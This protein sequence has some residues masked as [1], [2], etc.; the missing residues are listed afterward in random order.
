MKP[1]TT[2][3][4]ESK[5]MN[6]NDDE[7]KVCDDMLKSI[8][9]SDYD[10]LSKMDY[11]DRVSTTSP[12][13]GNKYFVEFKNPFA[14][15]HKFSN[16]NKDTIAPEKE[17][18]IQCIGIG[19]KFGRIFL[20]NVW[21]KAEA[22]IQYKKSEKIVKKDGSSFNT[23][24]G[25]Y[26]TRKNVNYYKV[27]GLKEYRKP[28]FYCPDDNISKDAYNVFIDQKYIIDL[29]NINDMVKRTIDKINKEA[30]RKREEETKREE[31][32]KFQ[33]ELKTYKCVGC[34][35]SWGDNVPEEVK[36]AKDD[37]DADWFVVNLG[38]GYNGY[39]S[40]KYKIYYTVDSTD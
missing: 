33:D 38:R 16:S 9:D 19:D 18:V 11:N 29:N 13:Y 5:F 32:K 2:Y 30:E 20:Q 14:D 6:L 28:V 17:E 25:W 3:I 36:K 1:L 35:N 22:Y 39:Y 34:A 10:T 23:N 40:K 37:S 12:V 4:K 31:I 8:I 24:S 21:N 7:L 15:Y 27:K 26:L